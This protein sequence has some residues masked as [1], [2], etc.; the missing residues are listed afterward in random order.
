MYVAVMK[1]TTQNLKVFYSSVLKIPF[2]LRSIIFLELFSKVV[3]NKDQ[4]CR[5]EQL[6][7][8][9]C[10]LFFMSNFW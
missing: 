5:R 7:T 10:F 9:T 3:F 8:L 1:K 2:K 4:G 6:I